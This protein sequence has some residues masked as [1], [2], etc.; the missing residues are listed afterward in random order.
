MLA[1]I[2]F[3]TEVVASRKEVGEKL[4]NLKFN[5]RQLIIYV[6]KILKSNV[7]VYQK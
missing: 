4:L 6:K 5:M 1:S 7:I 3:V 2:V